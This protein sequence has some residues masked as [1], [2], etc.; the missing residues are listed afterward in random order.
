MNPGKLDYSTVMINSPMIWNVL[1]CV[2]KQVDPNPRWS[3]YLDIGVRWVSEGFIDFAGPG[4][5]NAKALFE[6]SGRKFVESLPSSLMSWSDCRKK[7]E[8]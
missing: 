5:D 8:S 2:E 6:A 7:H 4:F 3:M 1:G